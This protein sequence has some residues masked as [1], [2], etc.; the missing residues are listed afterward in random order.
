MEA[1]MQ[2]SREFNRKETELCHADDRQ[3]VEDRRAS[4]RVTTVY[5]FGRLSNGVD[6]GPCRVQN[7]SDHG[8]MVMTGLTC[9]EGDTVN[10]DLSD[11]VVLRGEVSWSDGIRVG[12]ALFQSIDAAALLQSVAA[13]QNS[14]AHRATRLPTDTAAVA[15]TEQ[16]L[17][18]VRVTNISQRGVRI[19]HEGGFS[20][21]MTVKIVMENG[22]ERRAVVRWADSKSAG[23]Q[24]FEPFGY[25]DLESAAKLS[26]DTSADFAGHPANAMP[27]PSTLPI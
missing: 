26:P 11:S 6:S 3:L 24:L 22:L 17:R 12:I 18:V 9:V 5:R 21:G 13:Q 14:G 2:F 20:A 27:A 19:A 25:R 10:I 16:A 15:M 1:N 23:L 8:L 7:I 4:D